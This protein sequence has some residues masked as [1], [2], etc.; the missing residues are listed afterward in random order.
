MSKACVGIEVDLILF[1]KG[2]AAMILARLC[3]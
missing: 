2:T 3:C 1:C